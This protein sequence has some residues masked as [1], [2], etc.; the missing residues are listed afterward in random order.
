MPVAGS[1]RE[2]RRAA[3]V[4]HLSHDDAAAG[5]R[6]TVL[7]EHLGIEEQ[8]RK[9]GVVGWGHP[10]LEG[11]RHGRCDLRQVRRHGAGE[12]RQ[13]LAAGRY[14]A[15]DEGEGDREAQGARIT[16]GEPRSRH[17]DAQ[18]LQRRDG[19]AAMDSPQGLRLVVAIAG[20][21]DIIESHQRAM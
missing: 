19:A 11:R 21:H 3:P 10:D 9:A 5:H 18:A 13:P 14:D 16:P 17:P 7:R 6:R 15:D 20:D 8:G 4:M 1:E 12:A 2:A